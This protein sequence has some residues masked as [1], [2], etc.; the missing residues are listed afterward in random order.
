MKLSPEAIA[1]R[2]QALAVAISNKATCETNR[3]EA[4]AEYRASLKALDEQIARLAA[5]V[6]S[7]E[8]DDKQLELPEAG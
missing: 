8:C 7:G 5:E 4:A 6:E 1:L 2:A 3:K